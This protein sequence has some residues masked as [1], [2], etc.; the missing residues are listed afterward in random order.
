M[1]NPRGPGY[2]T[3]VAELKEA[4]RAMASAAGQADLDAAGFPPQADLSSAI[5][6]DDVGPEDDGGGSDDGFWGTVQDLGETAY[7]TIT[8]P[9]SVT[10]IDALGKGLIGAI[11][12]PYRKAVQ[13]V[14]VFGRDVS[15]SLETISTR[16]TE[17]AQIYQG[18]EDEGVTRFG[19]VEVPGDGPANTARQEG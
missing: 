7:N 19:D 13:A 5:P 8:S 3:D 11:N 17:A 18:N 16:I 9:G 15:D 4:A 6:F 1:G 14:S 2:Q 10:S 12:G